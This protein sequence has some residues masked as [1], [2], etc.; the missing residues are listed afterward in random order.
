MLISLFLTSIIAI[1]AAF[2]FLTMPQQQDFESFQHGD[3]I[4][5]TSGSGQSTAIFASTGS[6]FTH[7]GVLRQTKNGFV[8]MEA[9]GP[10]REM[11][12]MDWINRGTFKR[13]TVMRL[14]D[15]SKQTLNA[16]AEKAKSYFGLP[17]D[18]YFLFD[19]DRLYCSE[20]VYR[21]YEAAGVRLGKIQQ[22][23]ELNTGNRLA[24]NLYERRW[25]NH[26]VCRTHNMQSSQECWAIIQKEKL[27]TPVSI[28]HDDKLDLVHSNY[29]F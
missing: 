9:A 10:V 19:E 14:R 2:L 23:S 26:P 8:V 15:V 21:I 11:P 16:M 13:Y 4:F 24:K 20:F 17:Y 5:Q 28:A 25:K 7:M 29:P 12:I 18:P 3:L 22:M 27:I 6:L 1:F